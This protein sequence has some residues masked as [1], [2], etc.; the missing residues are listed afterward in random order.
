M[1]EIIANLK[2]VYFE[3]YLVRLYKGPEGDE[4][5]VIF[6]YSGLGFKYALKSFFGEQ[7]LPDDGFLCTLF[8]REPSKMSILYNQ[9]ARIKK[10]LNRVKKEGYT[11]GE[12]ERGTYRFFYAGEPFVIYS[13]LLPSDFF[14]PK[15]FLTV[16]I[17]LNCLKGSKE[18]IGIYFARRNP[19]GNVLYPGVE[20][21]ARNERDYLTRPSLFSALAM[22]V[23]GVG[24]NNISLF[25]L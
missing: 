19:D 6:E 8:F 1:N 15:S 9:I 16:K 23:I 17:L 13:I 10:E 18:L 24:K 7:K 11:L 3:R 5:S 12:F 2:K 22:H 21:V 14:S 25:E 4:K 20:I